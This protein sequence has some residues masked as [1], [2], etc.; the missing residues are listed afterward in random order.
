MRK[1]PIDNSIASI[2]SNM[3]PV[4]QEEVL[5]L[6]VAPEVLAAAYNKSRAAPKAYQSSEPLCKDE[7][8][9]QHG[10][11]HVCSMHANVLTDGAGL[12]LKVHKEFDPFGKAQH[13][14]GSKMDAG[15][16]RLSL[17]LGD[18]AHAL[19]AVGHVGTFGAQKYTDSGWMTVPNG[20]ERYTDALLRHLLKE[21][22]GE[23]NDPET[24]LYHASHAA[25]NAL[26]RLELLLKE[27]E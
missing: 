3:D 10:T 4:N 25:W 22:G 13:E 14:N 6:T 16:P 26:A 20:R 21:Q 11:P 5:A 2:L 12:Y 24:G 9:P 1:L 8:C 7:G 23:E 27:Q 17:V 18:F 15:K 19:I